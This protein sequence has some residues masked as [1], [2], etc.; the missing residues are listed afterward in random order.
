MCFDEVV[1]PGEVGVS[2]DEAL[3]DKRGYLVL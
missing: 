3:P 1:E 2:G